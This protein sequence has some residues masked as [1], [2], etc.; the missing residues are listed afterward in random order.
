MM[1]MEDPTLM[2]AIGAP[3]DLPIPAESA[4]IREHLYIHMWAAFWAGN[5]VVGEITAPAVRKLVRG[6][7]FN[8]RAGRAYWAAIR[9]NVLSTNEGKY[10]QFALIVDEEYQKVVAN[11]VPVAGPVRVT[12]RIDNSA[13][14][15]K[16]ELQQFALVGA[17][18]VTRVLA[19]RKFRQQDRRAR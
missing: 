5:Y 7:L 11:N 19:W 3:W 1:E 6:E 12:D 18:L 16:K 14:R 4:R 13:L 9:K 2:T 17:A 15:R 8:S 10:R